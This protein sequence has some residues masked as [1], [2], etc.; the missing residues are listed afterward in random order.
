MPG[1]KREM[2]QFKTTIKLD[3]TYTVFH[4]P[5][6]TWIQ[7]ALIVEP[8][9]LRHQRPG[10]RPSGVG[11]YVS[12]SKPCLQARITIRAS[13]MRAKGDCFSN[14][15]YSMYVVKHDDKTK[16]G[17]VPGHSLGEEVELTITHVS[18]V[19]I[20]YEPELTKMNSQMNPLGL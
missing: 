12:C 14:G 5:F 20:E 15:Q 4:D 2:S 3:H 13:M 17:S 7:Y 11:L 6:Y 9:Q 16:I 8:C 18:P 10:S 1:L 19:Q